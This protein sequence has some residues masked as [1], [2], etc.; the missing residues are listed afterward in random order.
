MLLFY[1]EM[2]LY[3]QSPAVNKTEPELKLIGFFFPLLSFYLFP[4]PKSELALVT[5]MR[6]I[7]LFISYEPDLESDY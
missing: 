3:I 4:L 6:G 1:V 7:F 5:A 2:L